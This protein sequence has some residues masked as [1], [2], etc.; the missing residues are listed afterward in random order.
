MIGLL[1]RRGCFWC[2]RL[3][4][5]CLTPSACWL[6][7][8]AAAAADD[9]GARASGTRCFSGGRRRWRRG[10]LGPGRGVSVSTQARMRVNDVRSAE[11]R[12]LGRFLC[13]LTSA[14]SQRLPRLYSVQWASAGSV[15]P[16]AAPVQQRSGCKLA[17]K[18]RADP[19][20]APFSGTRVRLQAQC[21]AAAGV[22]EPVVA[23][24]RALLSCLNRR[25]ACDSA[26]SAAAPEEV[27]LQLAAESSSR[28]CR[29]LTAADA[30]RF[31]SELCAP[32][33]L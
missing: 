2:V 31:V 13:C 3:D 4:V 29:P 26:A 5:T 25:Q 32:A 23:R 27:A 1:Y 9:G 17:R 20:V 19:P 33:D 12:S 16:I 15:R 6:Q 21:V 10:S 14:C 30:R 22:P 18:A 7:D 8:D 24:M 28:G 11:P